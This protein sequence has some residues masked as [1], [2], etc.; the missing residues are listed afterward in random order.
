MPPSIRVIRPVTLTVAP[1]NLIAAPP[2]SCP[3][4]DVDQP[5]APN[6]GL[7]TCGTSPPAQRLRD[8]TA[9]PSGRQLPHNSRHSTRRCGITHTAIL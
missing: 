5:P 4:S 6:L 9:P 1:P 3:R 8:L 7:A 2:L